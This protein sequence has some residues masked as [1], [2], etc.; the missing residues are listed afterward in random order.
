MYITLMH[1]S[2]DLFFTFYTLIHNERT[3]AGHVLWQCMIWF[4]F[5]MRIRA[6][7]LREASTGTLQIIRNGRIGH[8]R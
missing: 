7:G 6:T 1:V 8:C 2:Y 3:T 5:N 4:R